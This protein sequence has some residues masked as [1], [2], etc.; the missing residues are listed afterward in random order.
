MDLKDAES[1]NVLHCF[2]NL[3]SPDIDLLVFTST[4]KTNDD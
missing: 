4:S 3:S 1:T 2:G